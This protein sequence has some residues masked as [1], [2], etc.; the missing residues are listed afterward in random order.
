M[1]TLWGGKACSS[2]DSGVREGDTSLS[3]WPVLVLLAL[4]RSR[5]LG[6]GQGEGRSEKTRVS[7]TLAPVGTNRVSSTVL[8]MLDSKDLRESRWTKS[9][10][11]TGKDDNR[12]HCSTALPSRNCCVF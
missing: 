1:L 8:L 11:K 7:G 2:S 5:E 9:G 10:G 6:E 3:S 12:G 4:Y